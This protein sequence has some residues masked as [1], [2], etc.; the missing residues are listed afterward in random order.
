MIRIHERSP[1]RS[2]VRNPPPRNQS[3]CSSAGYA[4]LSIGANPA[5]SRGR[6]AVYPIGNGRRFEPDRSGT[7]EFPL[8]QWFGR[9]IGPAWLPLCAQIKCKNAQGFQ[10]PCQ[11][12]IND[13]GTSPSDT[14]SL[15]ML[16]YVSAIHPVHTV[17]LR[18]A[19][20]LLQVR[21]YVRSNNPTPLQTDGFK[22]FR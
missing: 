15:L 4:V 20:L 18:T 7:G 9:S 11:I 21:P 8:R 19:T 17:S 14:P 10:P 16:A 22:L 12:I 1:L 2:K 5:S 6:S 3:R 13:S